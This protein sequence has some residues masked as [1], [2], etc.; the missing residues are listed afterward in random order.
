MPFFA[1]STPLK[2]ECRRISFAS[3]APRRTSCMH[4][5]LRSVDGFWSH[6]SPREET[7]EPRIQVFWQSQIAAHDTLIRW[8]NRRRPER[9]TANSHLI[10]RRAERPPVH[11]AAIARCRHIRVPDRPIPV[12]VLV[13]RLRRFDHGVFGHSKHLWRDIVWRTGWQ[14]AVASRHLTVGEWCR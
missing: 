11:I 4:R 6:N 5:S 8:P 1:Q 9:S 12:L 3:D 7:L 13:G 10:Q 2:Y 14:H